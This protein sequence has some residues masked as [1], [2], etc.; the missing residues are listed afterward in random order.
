MERTEIC[1]MPFDHGPADNPVLRFHY[2][3]ASGTCRLF[4]WGGVFGNKN[5]FETKAECLEKC[6]GK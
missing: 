1:A 6:A 4:V 3:K 5:N 2:H